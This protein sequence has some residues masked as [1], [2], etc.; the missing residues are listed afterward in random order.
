MARPITGIDHALVG[1]R[2]LELARM[3]WTRLGFNLSPRGRHVGWG[4][5][6][7]CAMF[8]HDYIEL[9][10]IVD[11]GQFSN[12]LDQFLERREG[13]LG[14]AFGTGGGAA[15]AAELQRRGLHPS[16]PR[17]LA[18]QLELPEG[19]VLPRFELVFLPAEETPGLSAFICRHLTPE[20]LR[21]PVWLDHP[22]GAIG[23][24]RVGIVVEDTRP[25]TE[26]YRRLFG[27]TAVNSTDS[28]LSVHIGRH[29]LIFADIDDFT[30]M[31]P[32]AELDPGLA[33]PYVASLTIASR[34]I[35]RTKDHLTDWQIDY[36]E[37][38]DGSVLL[39]PAQANGVV[40]EF[41]A[42]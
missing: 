21:R 6:N 31:H 36:A 32:D 30:A 7:Y 27:E 20:L 13:A 12:G 15:A 23:L 3:A 22:N 8:E 33:P 24:K 40:L 39:P 16:A 14:L 5:A 42:G 28:V 29:K 11:P 10:G 9:L 19:T 35:E 38:P 34:D 41:V 4:T 2:D 25:L 17:D 1:V 37:G 18:R 26:P